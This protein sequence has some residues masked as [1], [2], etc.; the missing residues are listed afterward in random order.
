[1]LALGIRSAAQEIRNE[2]YSFVTVKVRR[3]GLYRKINDSLLIKAQW[4]RQSTHAGKRASQPMDSSQSLQD[5]R[6]FHPSADFVAP[7]RTMVPRPSPAGF[8]LGAGCAAL[9]VL[10]AAGASLVLSRSFV[11]ARTPAVGQFNLDRLPPS[12]LSLD[13]LD[14]VPQGR[15]DGAALG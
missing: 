7:V 1:M 6:I 3:P 15:P 4:S 8:L 5:A 12:S 14:A 13:T 11:D 9:L 10:T 2:I